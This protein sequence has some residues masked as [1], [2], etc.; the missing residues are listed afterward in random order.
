MIRYELAEDIGSE[1]KE[2][3]HKLELAHI[4]GTRVACVRSRGSASRRTLARCH[5]FPKIMQ[6]ALQMKPHYIIEIISEQFDK[7]G[8]EEQTKVLIHEL[9]HIPHSFGGGFRSHRPYVTRKKVEK[10][11]KK[12]LQAG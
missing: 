6:L 12:F 11:Y 9:M 10:M 8:K 5:G 2:I 3:I 1:I 4:D 7:L